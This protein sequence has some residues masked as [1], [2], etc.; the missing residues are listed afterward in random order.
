M[1]IKAEAEY[2]SHCR[3]CLE[4]VADSDAAVGMSEAIESW[5]FDLTQLHL[6]VSSENKNISY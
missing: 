1:E 3:L 5:F 4:A 6:K 2:I